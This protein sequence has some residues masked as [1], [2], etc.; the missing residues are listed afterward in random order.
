MGDLRDLET[1]EMCVQAALTGHLVLTAMLP[2][3]A[4]SVLTRLLDMG[5]SPFLVASAV[6]AVLAQRLVRRLCE[7][8]RVKY[9]PPAALLADLEQQTGLPLAGG[10]FYRPGGCGE[11]REYGYRG[12]AAVFELLEMDLPVKEAV[13]ARAPVAEIRRA[14]LDAGMT[15]MLQ[16]GLRK[17]KE[18]LTSLEKVMRVLRVMGRE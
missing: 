18:G 11:C 5:V 17:A 10:T 3:D 9:Q 4:P 2:P 14:A 16:D 15:T 8:C 12:R 6:T 13:L 1:A 7:K